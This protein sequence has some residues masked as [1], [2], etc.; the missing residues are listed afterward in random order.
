MAR[1]FSISS[2][3]QQ[4]VQWH[5]SNEAATQERYAHRSLKQIFCNIQGLREK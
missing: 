4:K 3:R 5:V 2:V 1:F